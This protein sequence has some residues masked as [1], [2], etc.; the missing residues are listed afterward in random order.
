MTVINA[1]DVWPELLFLDETAEWV[2]LDDGTET[3]RVTSDD[4]QGTVIDDT[5]TADL[6]TI[7]WDD[8]TVERR[9]RK[10]G[11]VIIHRLQS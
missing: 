11:R 4:D 9:E 8:G 1:N 5:Y 7:R 10:I 6:L 3:W 2:T